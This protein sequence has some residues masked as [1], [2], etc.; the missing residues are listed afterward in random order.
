MRKELIILL[1]LLSVFLAIGCAGN[2]GEAP[3]ATAT[4]ATAGAEVITVSAAASLTEAFTDI[5]SQ[6][7]TEILER[8]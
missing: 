4:P 7:E 8:R 6:F 1:V 5:A 2:K 3:N